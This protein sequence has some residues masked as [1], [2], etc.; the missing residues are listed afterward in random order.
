[1]NEP[2]ND[3]AGLPASAVQFLIRWRVVVLLVVVILAAGAWP[4][5][6]QIQFDRSIES[7]Y[8]EDDDHLQ[9]YSR[10]RALFGGDEFAAVA[11][12]EDGLFDPKSGTVSETSR[13]RLDAMADRLSRVPG[14]FPDSTQ[15][16][17]RATDMKRGMSAAIDRLDLPA[18]FKRLVPLLDWLGGTAG[19]RRSSCG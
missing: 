2:P 12:S 4:L 9:A 17:G 7:L 3:V 5:A 16:V 11:W 14:V 8:T 19:L 6:S 10:S 1:M 15:H 13:Q 18:V